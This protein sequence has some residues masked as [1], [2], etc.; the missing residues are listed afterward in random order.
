MN[1]PCMSNIFDS[2][3]A[4]EVADKNGTCLNWIED[5]LQKLSKELN[6]ENLGELHLDFVSE[7]YA[8][9]C[10]FMTTELM[11]LDDC[12]NPPVCNEPASAVGSSLTYNLPK[13]QEGSL[14]QQTQDLQNLTNTELMDMP[15]RKLNKLLVGQPKEKVTEIRYRRRCLKNRE[16]ANN[17]RRKKNQAK[18]SLECSVMRL[19]KE[20]SR[21]RIELEKVEKE[22]DSYKNQFYIKQNLDMA[23][24]STIAH[25]L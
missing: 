5:A 9:D 23:V 2:Q 21:M 13:K 10:F 18:E 16:Y 8:D 1:Q 20:L 25:E 12:L 19:Q 7:S 22:R 11:A 15:V 4:C 6:S 14:S 24:D 3:E 17:S